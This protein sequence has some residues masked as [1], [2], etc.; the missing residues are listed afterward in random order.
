MPVGT[1]SML[2]PCLLLT[3]HNRE[4]GSRALLGL[5]CWVRTLI[6]PTGYAPARSTNKAPPEGGLLSLSLTRS[7]KLSRPQVTRGY[8]SSVKG[9]LHGGNWRVAIWQ[10]SEFHFLKTINAK[11]EH[12][13]G[14]PG[15]LSQLS[16]PRLQLR[17]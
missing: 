1:L 14:A 2:F 11:K 4:A 6:T 9:N 3:C 5:C 12:C 15:W 13:Q 7:C 16:I 10:K 17:S 8:K